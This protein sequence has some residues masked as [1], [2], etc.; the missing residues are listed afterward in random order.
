MSLSAITYLMNMLHICLF[1]IKVP[2]VQ[3]VVTFHGVVVE[4][5]RLLY[6]D[7][8]FKE[9]FAILSHHMIEGLRCWEL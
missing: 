7:E 3:T 9:L 6:S 1:L 5:I 4:F 8:I 2:Q